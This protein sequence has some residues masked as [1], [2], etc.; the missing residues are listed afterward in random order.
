MENKQPSFAVLLAA[1][2]GME[3]IE[4]Q[5]QSILQQQGV[6]ITIFISVDLSDDDTYER[7]LNYVKLNS[8]IK[9]LSYGKR[10]GGAAQNFF[11]LISEVEFL[12][13]DYVALADQDD[14]WF[15][16]KLCYGIKQM[17]VNSAEAYSASVIAFWEDGR[18]KLIDKSQPQKELDYLFEAAGP[19]CTYIFTNKAANLIKQYLDSF[20]ELNDFVLHDWLA[21][22]ILRH[23]KYKWF[24]DSQPKMYYRQHEDNQVGANASIKAKLYRVKYILSGQVFKSIKVLVSALD[25]SSIKLSSRIDLFKLVLKARQLRRRKIDQV[26]VSIALIVY[27]ILGANR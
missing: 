9:V 18:K 10:F 20:P 22:A 11:R 23:N 15:V 19:G 6:N 2:N 8:N 13:F 5:L 27:A 12:D 4:Q 7:C 25:I 16:D 14:E 26:F 21:Y 3:Y 24:I 17:D 1:Y